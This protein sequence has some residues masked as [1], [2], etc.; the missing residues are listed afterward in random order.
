MSLC[1]AMT[2]NAMFNFP[3]CHFILRMAVAECIFCFWHQVSVTVC[4]GGGVQRRL[5][6]TMCGLLPDE[7]NA[8]NDSR[9]AGK[10]HICVHSTPHKVQ[11]SSKQE[12]T[13]T[14]VWTFQ[15]GDPQSIGVPLPPH[16]R[17]SLPFGQSQVAHFSLCLS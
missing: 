8:S 4:M 3:G 13:G 12:I 11:F 1:L 5:C 14:R 9:K 2:S 10:P 16:E 15:D 6:N 7:S 17:G